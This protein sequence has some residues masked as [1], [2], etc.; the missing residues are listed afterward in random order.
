[1]FVD[2]SNFRAASAFHGCIPLAATD[3]RHATNFDYSDDWSHSWETR[4][5]T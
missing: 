4:E 5:A 1:M 3:E 2:S